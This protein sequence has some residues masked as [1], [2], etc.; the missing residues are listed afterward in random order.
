MTEVSSWMHSLKSPSLNEGV[1]S[2]VKS[3]D[4]RSKEGLCRMKKSMRRL[5]LKEMLSRL[6]DFI[7]IE[8]RKMERVIDVQ[9]KYQ[10]LI[11]TVPEFHVSLGHSGNDPEKHCFDGD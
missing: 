9:D 11:R 5:L 8:N 7:R 4:F 6:E 2:Q 1:K 3:D 10:L